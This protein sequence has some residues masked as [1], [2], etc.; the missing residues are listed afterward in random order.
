MNSRIISVVRVLKK[1]FIVVLRFT[2][3][4]FAFFNVNLYMALYTRFLSKI[5]VQIV[6]RPKFINRDVYFDGSDYSLIRIGDNVVISREV[7]L[8]THDYTL[9]AALGAASDSFTRRGDGE[10]YTLK[11]IEIGDNSF[12]G[13][14]AS[15]L[16]GVK[17][18]ANV[19]VGAGSVVVSHLP[20]NVI[21]AGNPCRPIS[22]TTEWGVRKSQENRVY[23]D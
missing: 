23:F 11:G 10:V 3:G 6:G 20:D 7:M 1:V 19:I 12:I 21:A 13:A 15:I 4:L 2:I 18:G 5:G 16:P 22:T 8:L 14:R 17:I 9:T